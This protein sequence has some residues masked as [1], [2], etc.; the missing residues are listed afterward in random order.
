MKVEITLNID[1]HLNRIAK[2][3]RRHIMVIGVVVLAVGL[4]FTIN[5]AWSLTVFFP[6][7]MWNQT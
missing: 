5:Y 1:R 4:G 3:F 2:W 7:C 6:V